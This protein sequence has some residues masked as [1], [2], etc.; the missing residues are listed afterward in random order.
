MAHVILD[1]STFPLVV[2]TLPEEVHGAD[3]ERLF[4]DYAAVYARHEQFAAI[5]DLSRL[6]KMPGAKE[7][8]MIAE[9]L[10]SMD[11]KVRRYGL[12]T[13]L[14]VRSPLVRGALT[15]TGWIFAPPIPHF[16]PATFEEALDIATAQLHAAGLEAPADVSALRRRTAAR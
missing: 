8:K 12:C 4:A 7:R 15:A 10:R 2:A 9:W 14:L 16:Y 6:S 11:D 13:I 5:T 1:T 3:L